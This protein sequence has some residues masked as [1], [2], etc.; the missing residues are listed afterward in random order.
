MEGKFISV[1]E[2]ALRNVLH[3]IK[4]NDLIYDKRYKLVF[5]ALSLA[6]E[7]GYKAGVRIDEE[8]PEWPV[9]YIELPTGQVSWHMPQHIKKWDGHTTEEKYKRVDEYNESKML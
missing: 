8:E 5:K 2:M 3:K 7:L 4:N 9:V 6:I 1:R